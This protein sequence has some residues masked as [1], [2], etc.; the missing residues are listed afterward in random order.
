MELSLSTSLKIEQAGTLSVSYT[1]RLGRIW[2]ARVESPFAFV[3]SK[4]VESGISPESAIGASRELG[5]FAQNFL[6]DILNSSTD[7][8]R[9]RRKSKSN[10]I[11]AVGCGRGYDLHWVEE[12]IR[13]HLRTIWLDVSDVACQA[14]ITDLNSQFDQIPNSSSLV[15]LR[16]LVMK[17]EIRS[18][19]VDP[20]SAG[21]DLGSVEI[22]YLCRVLGCLSARS[23][24][25]VLQYLGRSLALCNGS[26]IIV[27]ALLDDNEKYSGSKNSRLMSLKYI[28]KHLSSG[29]RYDVEVVKKESYRYFDK[30]VTALCIR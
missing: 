6:K 15:H 26:I 8:D 4:I 24:E 12:A 23:A 17:A 30:I 10:K 9:Q 29:S 22:W 21:L 13:A 20:E 2:D 27:G 5:E 28:L 1:K 7:A 25:I 11:V 3:P 14:A 19:L 18:A 16:P